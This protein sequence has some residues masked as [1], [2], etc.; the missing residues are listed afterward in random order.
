MEVGVGCTRPA[1]AV[2]FGA[3]EPGIAGHA[4][5]RSGGLSPC[6]MGL[7][8]VPVRRGVRGGGWRVFFRVAERVG[9]VGM[10]SLPVPM[11]RDMNEQCNRKFF[12]TR[13]NLM[14]GIPTAIGKEIHAGVS[15]QWS[16]VNA[17]FAVRHCGPIAVRVRGVGMASCMGGWLRCRD[18]GSNPLCPWE[19]HH[20]AL[21]LFLYP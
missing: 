14:Q 1:G 15:Q 3:G 20:G 17:G 19:C 16:A 9:E 10:E 21:L 8:T 6:L 13:G 11:L 18:G 4:R 5:A 2:R 7:G 12:S